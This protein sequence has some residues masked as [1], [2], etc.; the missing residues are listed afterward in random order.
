M[1]IVFRSFSTKSYPEFFKNLTIFKNYVALRQFFDS[2][3]YNYTKILFRFFQIFYQ[4]YTSKDIEQ[5]VL[6]NCEEFCP[7]D[8]FISLY[9]DL[10]P[11]EE[12]CGI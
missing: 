3:Y 12:L 10:L 8:K 2:I 5:L 9:K 11:T 7:L 6:P 1:Q 4:H